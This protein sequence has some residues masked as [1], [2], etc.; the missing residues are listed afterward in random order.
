MTDGLGS[1]TTYEYDSTGRL[2]T[3]TDPI[4]IS[5][6]YTYDKTGNKL[7][8]TDGRGK[9]TSYLYGAFRMLKSVKDADEKTMTCTYDLA[10]NVACVT[11]RN[12]NHTVYTYDS[13]NLLTEKKV[14]ETGEEIGYSYDEVGNRA[15]MTDE[16]GTSTYRYDANNRLL[17]IEK[18]GVA[19]ISYTYDA[20]GNIGT[21]TDRKGFT[22]AY[23]YDKSSRMKTVEFDG[24]ITTY[25]YDVNGNRE[26]VT[27]DSGLREE[28]T[29]DK[30]NRVTKV[31]NK[32]PSGGEISSYSYTY[33]KAGRQD[34]KTNKFGI[35]K[36]IYDPA[37]RVL[38][39]E[40][41][42]KTTVYSYD[43]AGNRQTQ[44]ETYTSAQPTGYID[45]A[46]AK[47][48]QYILKKTDY[49]Y[50][51]AN[52]LLK[53]V[54]RMYDE[55]S[56][57]VLQKTVMYYYDDNGNELSQVASYIHPHDMKLRQATRGT[58]AADNMQNPIDPLIE[59]VNN[60]FDGFNRLKKVESVK[61][62]VR[63]VAEYLYNGDDLRVK[64]VVKSS[65]KQYAGIVTHYFY[66][67][68]HVILETDGSDNIAVRYVRG[69]NYIARTGSSGAYSYFLFNGHGD[70]VQ[71]VSESGE[72]ENNYDYD[73]WGTP[74]LTVE[75]YS[76]A[77][78]Y[79]GEYMDVET[80]LYYLRARYYDAYLGRFIS[81][82]SY[83]GE[84]TNPLSLNLYTYCHNDPVLCFL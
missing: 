19:E 42:G 23:T 34:S 47:D 26:S 22:A 76:C 59:R 35:T 49:A 14:L 80:G 72:V 43:G 67:R 71:T 18:D 52:K 6:S 11:D 38:K 50:S 73:I 44:A 69:I 74:T 5:V 15:E 84:D 27:Y 29:Y 28:Y 7:F 4:G 10:G 13:R 54:E 56:K 70:V 17:K 9:V 1:T 30:N 8:M 77:I 46:S 55:A 12:G 36:Y 39:V 68:Q 45:E 3:V 48:V 60:T 32:K 63:T 25:A 51:N 20:I 16:S 31:V 81:E 65:D 62:G 75:Q 78:R 61:G 40:A 66:D 82:D 41:P 83:W 24:K 33:D 2:L 37:G 58:L 21:V 64:K 57:E 53:S 79:A